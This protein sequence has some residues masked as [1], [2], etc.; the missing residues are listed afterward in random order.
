MG[1]LNNLLTHY[2]LQE[3]IIIFFLFISAAIS[4]WK[5]YDFFTDKYQKMTEKRKIEMEWKEKISCALNDLDSKIDNL[6]NQNQKIYK[7]QEQVD[8]T[9]A[10]VQERM[11]E[12]SR[13]FLI[14]AHHKFCY[15]YKK[16]D[17]LNLQSI[18]RR[19]LYYKTAGGNTFID[20]LM[21]EIRSLPRVNFF[22]DET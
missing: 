8:A 3:L 5:M 9:L 13:S 20:H 4:I 15:K 1:E 12:N 21:E 10:L 2:P 16:I 22:T 7:K 19:Y 11:Q 17:D 14:D 6:N 18:E